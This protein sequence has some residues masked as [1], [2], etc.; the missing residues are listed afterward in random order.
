MS[1]ELKSIFKNKLIVSILI[2]FIIFRF[3]AIYNLKNISVSTTQY[4]ILLME[5]NLESLIK[6]K[7]SRYKE[8]NIKDKSPNKYLYKNYVGAYE[9]IQKEIIFFIKK[10]ENNDKVEYKEFLKLDILCDLIETEYLASQSGGGNLTPTKLFPKKVDR[11]L[12]E[13]DFEYNIYDLNFL[14]ESD[15]LS[16][17]RDRINYFLKIIDTKIDNYFQKEVYPNSLEYSVYN[18]IRNTNYGFNNTWTYWMETFYIGILPLLIFYLVDVQRKNGTIKNIY[19]RSTN[20][21]KNYLY[22]VIVFLIV[23]L[24]IIYFPKITSYIYVIITGQL[25]DVNANVIVFSKGLKTFQTSY[26]K[27][28]DYIF[29]YSAHGMTDLKVGLTGGLLNYEDLIEMS[30]NKFISYFVTIDILKIILVVLTSTLISLHIKNRIV[31]FG[32][33]FII[34]IMLIWGGK[35]SSKFFIN[36]FN[37]FIL[38]N[39]WKLTIGREYISYYNALVLLIFSIIIIHIL[40]I[41]ISNCKEIE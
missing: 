6:T 22:Y 40:S 33:N 12:D 27:Y 31:S 13:I 5:N 37:P 11:F 21:Y 39:G 18:F 1:K 4:A 19:L 38:P 30:F 25:Y 28:W 10:L 3:I 9:Y 29:Q 14:P 41:I 7:S 32:L 2:L 16:A 8:A 35:S 17:Y 36:K 26:E 20:K 34:S 24:L 15:E 23:S